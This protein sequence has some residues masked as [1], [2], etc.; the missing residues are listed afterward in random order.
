M[1]GWRWDQGGPWDSQGIEGVVR[2]LNRVW[3]NVLEPGPSRETSPTDDQVRALR[4]KVHQAI[5]RGTEDMQNFSFNTF[6]ANLMELNNAMLKAKEAG[7]YRT[8]A[9]SE[10]VEAL[11]LMLAPACPHIA[12]ELW[13]RT[14]RPYS[15]HA[16][17]WPH[18][19]EAVAAE[20]T[21]TIPV[22]VNGRV[23]DRIQ[24]PVDVDKETMRSLALQTEGAQRHLEGKTIA[25]VVVVP[26]RLINIVVK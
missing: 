12:E 5:R 26:G 3:E 21:I 17:A 20:E 2:F 23:R 4:R 14:G 11:L 22:Q 1:F 15:I 24:V 7:L 10:A 25:Q 13:A 19:D 16:Q 8:E 18:W 6:I 9:W